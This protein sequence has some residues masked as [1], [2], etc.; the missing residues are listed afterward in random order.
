MSKFSMKDALDVIIEVVESNYWEWANFE[1][2]NQRTGV[3]TIL[4]VEDDGYKILST[5]HIS[6]LDVYN[7]FHAFDSYAKENLPGLG[8]IDW[9]DIDWEVCDCFIQFVCFGEVRYG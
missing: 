5:H 6:P 8:V 4:E 9:E 1:N 3:V 7:K 2:Y